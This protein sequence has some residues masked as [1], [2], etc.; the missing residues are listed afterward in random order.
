[1]STYTHTQDYLYSTTNNRLQVWKG[2][3]NFVLISQAETHYGAIYSL[4]VSRRFLVTG[5]RGR[6]ERERE[7]KGE[8]GEGRRDLGTQA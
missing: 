1:M 4:A 8:G 2:S 6:G 5:E 7:G 3:D